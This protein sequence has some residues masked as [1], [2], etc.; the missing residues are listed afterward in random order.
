VT[1]VSFCVL[2][3][4]PVDD[5]SEVLVAGDRLGFDAAY[6]ADEIYHQDP[7]QMLAIAARQTTRIELRCTTHVVLHDPTYVAQRLMTLDALSGGRAGLLYSVGNL[8][9]LAQYRVD[10]PG[11]RMIGRLREAHTAMRTFIETA[12]LDLD[13][14][15]YQ[16]DGVFTSAKAVQEHIPLTMGGTRGPKTFELAGEIADGLMTGLVYSQ[17]A[18]RYARRHAEIGAA[19]SGRSME[20][21]ELGA[22]LIG[23]IAKDGDVAR[24]ASRVIAAFYIPTLPDETAE[25]HG[26]DPR[27]LVPIREA[28]AGGDVRKGIAITP[29]DIADRLT[30]PVGTPEEWVE[31]LNG[32]IAE[33]YNHLGLTPIDA[34]M[35]EQLTGE[36]I[37]GL[38][39]FVEQL[40]LIHEHV[41]PALS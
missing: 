22:G 8:A 27:R 38:P 21:F 9:M 36:R 16:Y 29:D 20:G 40:E 11:L 3:D 15:F 12:K 1:K 19:R 7:W 2:P 10:I 24:R 5:I 39:T 31:Q 37:E 18:L 28:F 23:A 14:R 41:L 6:V 34:P 25:R 35:V 4:N 32:V 30:L 33:G 17:E 26:I 13:G